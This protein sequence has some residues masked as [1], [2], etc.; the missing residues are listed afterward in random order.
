MYICVLYNE[1][2]SKTVVSDL[3]CLKISYKYKSAAICDRK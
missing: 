2:M 3:L 1:C